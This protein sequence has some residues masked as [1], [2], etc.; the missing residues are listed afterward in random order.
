MI[1]L[2]WLILAIVLLAVAGFYLW[3]TLPMIRKKPVTGK[4]S[5]IGARGFVHSENLS[6]EGE[7]SV[8][9]V[10]WKARLANPATGS[11]KKG[12]MIVVR[13]VEE[14]ALLVERS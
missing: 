10:V 6:L 12:D 7:V 1:D 14:L 13:G 8:D 11:L 9:G 4:E 2:S 3:Y 5:L